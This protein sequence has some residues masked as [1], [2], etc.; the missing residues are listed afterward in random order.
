MRIALFV[1]V[2]SA[3]VQSAAAAGPQF[4]YNFSV[5]PQPAVSTDTLTVTVEAFTTQCTPLP[6]A[7][8]LEDLGD[9]VMQIALDGSDACSSAPPETRSYNV[10]ALPPGSYLFRFAKCGINVL[11]GMPDCV[12]LEDVPVLVFGVASAPSTVPTLS[13]GGALTLVLLALC[14]GYWARRDG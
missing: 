13:L 5:S 3:M 11:P 6:A 10:G 2:L 7:I 14:F 12:T 8:G 9:G 1:I 4:G